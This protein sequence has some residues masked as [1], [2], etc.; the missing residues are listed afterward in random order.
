MREVQVLY[1]CNYLKEVIQKTNPILFV[2]TRCILSH[3][4]SILHVLFL[5]QHHPLE[6]Q[7]MGFP[8]EFLFVFPQGFVKV[9][10]L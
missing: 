7:S 8:F 3:F 9:L 5:F 6:I 10:T 2:Q 4:F 1:I